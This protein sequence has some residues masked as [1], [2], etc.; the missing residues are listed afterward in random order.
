MRWVA[1]FVICG[2][3]AVESSSPA[4]PVAAGPSITEG[5]E[6]VVKETSIPGHRIAA[7]KRRATRPAA[8]SPYLKQLREMVR[9]SNTGGFENLLKSSEESKRHVDRD[10]L[11]R[12]AEA[13]MKAKRYADAI[14]IYLKILRADPWDREALKGYQEASRLSRRR[15]VFPETPPPAGGGR[16]PPREAKTPEKSSSPPAS[17]L[18]SLFDRA[19]EAYRA[20]KL[21]EAELLYMQLLN[22]AISSTDPKAPF[23][24]RAAKERIKELTRK[25][26]RQP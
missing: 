4:I 15:L 9:T 14:S 24:Y 5:R 17:S 16:K 19:E 13:A 18:Q 11:L 25:K 10:R 7:P 1:L 2:C 12:L 23:F 20:G 8:P 22:E 26:E 21:R 3:T 6:M